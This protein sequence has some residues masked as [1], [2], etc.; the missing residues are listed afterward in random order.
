MRNAREGQVDDCRRLVRR[1][2]GVRDHLPD[3]VLR[4]IVNLGEAAV[5]ALVEI[6]EG[7]ARALAQ[8]AGG[9][10]ARVHAAWLLGELRAAGAAPAM[11][12]VLAGIDP[13]DLLHDQLIQSL[14]RSVPR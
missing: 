12:R 11:L 4:D 14:P 8:A 2:I 10:Q 1:I 13:M 6:L 5:P 3:D 7:D 9:G